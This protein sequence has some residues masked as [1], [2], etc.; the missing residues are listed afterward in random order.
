MSTATFYDQ[1]RTA[2]TNRVPVALA[3]VV[4]GT[5]LGAKVLILPDEVQ[6]R[7]GDDA[8]TGQIT[9]DAR[10]LL[11][12]ERSETRPYELNGE[13][14][15]IFIESFP[16]PPLLVIFGAVHVAQPLSRLGKQL[17]FRVVVTDARSPLA[18]AERFPDADEIIVAWPDDALTQIDIAP[19]TF[20]AILTHDPKF[21]EPALSGALTTEARYI[22]AVGSRKTNEDR[23]ERL[24]AAGVDE[25]HLERLHAPIGLNIGGETPEE[26]AISILAEMIAVRHGRPGGQ[27]SN[28]E[29]SIRGQVTSPVG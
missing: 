20:I 14:I 22:G 26:M 12:D 24:R 10:S 29:G 6:G 1:V 3:T 7:I 17:G 11:R 15:E 13:P 25:A 9:L 8:L 19:T 2:V 18:T 27:L 21:D 16:P 4:R 5:S 28:A 23:R